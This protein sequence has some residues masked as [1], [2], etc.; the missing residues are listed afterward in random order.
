MAKNVKYI[1]WIQKSL[2]QVHKT[3]LGR[4]LEILGFVCPRQ[5]WVRAP[6][7]ELCTALGRYLCCRLCHVCHVCFN[8][9]KL[10]PRSM[11]FSPGSARSTIPSRLMW[12]PE[13]TFRVMWLLFWPCNFCCWSEDFVTFLREY[14]A[15]RDEVLV[16]YADLSGNVHKSDSLISQHPHCLIKYL[17]L[18]SKW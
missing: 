5:T 14:A 12:Q 15:Y 3:D 17:F 11:R 6:N 13:V 7:F 18:R 4:A 2:V 10:A 8:T 16:G 1:T 9:L